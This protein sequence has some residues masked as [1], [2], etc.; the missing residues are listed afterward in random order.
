ME[1]FWEFLGVED[2]WVLLGILVR[3][4]A[5]IVVGAV[6]GLERERYY[7]SR[8]QTKAA[9]IRTYS[10][11]CFG[12][13]LFGIASIHGFQSHLLNA[14]GMVGD[15]GRVAAQ[16]VAG[17]GFLGAGAIIKDHGQIRG[18]TTAAGLWVAAALGLVLSSKLF[19]I[20][21]I[22]AILT[23]F[24]LDLPRIFPGLFRFAVQDE[25]EESEHTEQRDEKTASH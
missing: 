6:I 22:A 14:A 23:Y 9:G 17:V 12:S 7:K 4:A 24:M 16:V 13:C 10:L 11:V 2:G 18:L 8:N 15:P 3:M 25:P 19:V 1:S 5:A 21:L 20:G